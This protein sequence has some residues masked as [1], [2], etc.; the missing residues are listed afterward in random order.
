MPAWPGDSKAGLLELPNQDTNGMAF[1]TDTNINIVGLPFPLSTNP[2]PSVYAQQILQQVPQ[3]FPQQQGTMSNS[4]WNT[5]LGL[6]DAGTCPTQSQASQVHVDML[7]NPVNGSGSNTAYSGYSYQYAAHGHGAAA[8]SSTHDADMDMG[9]ST[10]AGVGMGM[11]MAWDQTAGPA[12]ASSSAQSSAVSVGDLDLAVEGLLGMPGNGMDVDANANANIDD[13]LDLASLDMTL[14]HLMAEADDPTN[15]FGFYDFRNGSI[16]TP[17][18]FECNMHPQTGKQGIDSVLSKIQLYL[19][20]MGGTIGNL[21]KVVGHGQVSTIGYSFEKTTVLSQAVGKDKERCRIVIELHVTSVNGEQ[22]VSVTS[23]PAAVA[24]LKSIDA[25]WMRQFY[26]Q[27]FRSVAREATAAA[28]KKIA[29]S[30]LASARSSA[31]HTAAAREAAAVL[32]EIPR[33]AGLPQQVPKPRTAATPI[34]ST[35]LPRSDD[36]STGTDTSSSSEDYDE[37]E[38]LKWGKYNYICFAKARFDHN[39]EQK[40]LVPP[41]LSFRKGDEIKVLSQQLSGDSLTGWWVAENATGEVGSFPCNFFPKTYS[42]SQEYLAD[43]QRRMRDAHALTKQGSP[44]GADTA[45]ATLPANPES[46][47]ATDVTHWL[48]QSGLAEFSDVVCANGYVGSR[49]LQLSAGQLKTKID[50]IQCDKLSRS[51]D[52]LR[53]KVPLSTNPRTWSTWDVKRWLRSSGLSDFVDAFHASK[54]AGDTILSVSA[55]D[56]ASAE[57]GPRRNDELAQALNSLRT[58]VLPNEGR[59]S[60]AEIKEL[61]NSSTNPSPKYTKVLYD[62]GKTTGEQL[63][64][65]KGE[66]LTVVDDTQGPWWQAR[67]SSGKVGLVPSNFLEVVVGPSKPGKRA[68]DNVTGNLYISMEKLVREHGAPETVP[69]VLDLSVAPNMHPAKEATGAQ[70]V[71][72]KPPQIKLFVGQPSLLVDS[73][74]NKQRTPSI[75]K[76]DTG[77]P[78]DPLSGWS[79]QEEAWFYPLIRRQEAEWAISQGDTGTFLV[80]PSKSN[81][82]SYTLIVKGPRQLREQGHGGV[83][84][85]LIQRTKDAFVLGES[86]LEFGSVTKLIHHYQKVGFPLHGREEIT[87][88]LNR[89]A[90]NLDSPAGIG[91]FHRKVSNKSVNSDASDRSNRAPTKIDLR[92]SLDSLGRKG[93]SNSIHSDASDYIDHAERKGS[94]RGSLLLGSTKSEVAALTAEAAVGA[95]HPKPMPSTMP[96]RF[97]TPASVTPCSKQLEARLK[98]DMDDVQMA[99]AFLAARADAEQ[100]LLNQ[101][102]AAF[103]QWEGAREEI[104]ATA[105]H[106]ETLVDTHH[107]RYTEKVAQAEHARQCVLQCNTGKSYGVILPAA[108]DSKAPAAWWEQQEDVQQLR[109]E[110]WYHGRISRQDAQQQLVDCAPGSYLVRVSEKQLGFAVTAVHEDNKSKRGFTHIMVSMHNDHDGTPTQWMVQ[111][112]QFSSVKQMIEYYKQRPYPS[113]GWFRLCPRELGCFEAGQQ[114]QPHA[115][116]DIGGVFDVAVFKAGEDAIQK[117]IAAEKEAIDEAQVAH[118]VYVLGVAGLNVWCSQIHSTLFPLAL[119]HLAALHETQAVEFQEAMAKAAA[120]FN[121]QGSSYAGLKQAMVSV[122]P[123]T[124]DLMSEL[125]AEFAK[126]MLVARSAGFN[127]PAQTADV[128]D[129]CVPRTSTIALFKGTEKH[130]LALVSETESCIEDLEA[131]I[132]SLKFDLNEIRN[133]GTG[134]EPLD[135]FEPGTL[136]RAKYN[137]KLVTIGGNRNDGTDISYS[138]MQAACQAMDLQRLIAK[139]ETEK[140]MFGVQLDLVQ[141]AFRGPSSK[142]VRQFHDDGFY[143]ELQA[144]VLFAT[145]EDLGRELPKLVLGKAALQPSPAS[146]FTPIYEQ[147]KAKYC[148]RSHDDATTAAAHVPYQT[149]S[150]APAPA[151]TTQATAQPR[152]ALVANEPWF[153]YKVGRREIEQVLTQSG[154]YLVR[155]SNK[156]PGQLALS[157][158]GPEHYQHHALPRSRVTHFLIQQDAR[159]RCSL[160][161][162]TFASIR[163]LVQH[164][165]ETG[166]PVTQASNV[167]LVHGV[168]RAGYGA[169]LSLSDDE[170][171]E[172]EDEGLVLSATQQHPLQLTRANISFGHELTAGKKAS[173][174]VF[175]ASLASTATQPMLIVAVKVGKDTSSAH[176]RQM[177]NEADMLKSC[178]HPNIVRLVGVVEAAL[179]TAFEL[180]DRGDLLSHIRTSAP[181]ISN[182]QR[183]RLSSEVACGLAYLHNKIDG[184]YRVHCDLAAR[185]CLVTAQNTVKI[186]SF[187]KSR[188]F[189]EEGSTRWLNA[190]DSATST[191]TSTD[192]VRWASPE[193]VHNLNFTTSSDVWAFGILL[194]EIFSGGKVPYA[195]LSN[196]ETKTGLLG[197]YLN[198]GGPRISA[199]ASAPAPITQLINE[200]HLDNAPDRPT[201]AD[202][203]DWFADDGTRHG[204]GVVDHTKR[205]A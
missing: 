89:A 8:G 110:P 39:T 10:G 34:L 16:I 128:L 72:F 12:S 141:I 82:G 170:E 184:R 113:V 26:S 28:R 158:F 161:G 14:Q 132:S 183:T 94:G 105:K 126:D 117:A 23:N 107:A 179:Y 81:P 164:Y 6:Q 193:V 55:A 169:R 120:A 100:A 18:W 155:E 195:D 77:G 98:Q 137:Q 116:F 66:I 42:Y 109:A 35:T 157:V 79:M 190:H 140:H 102:R 17:V 188:V 41:P 70:A 3:Q 88:A 84:Q 104:E 73:V 189:D 7:G 108:H 67:D 62:Y 38:G 103:A 177:L 96:P 47:V 69:E 134:I 29:L 122:A 114:Q 92:A 85:L 156:I 27:V 91:G 180:C 133:D 52:T 174:K 32:L 48:K 19:R 86:N 25:L 204:H 154:D 71:S 61:A 99:M 13:M 90:T 144:M 45:A 59:G 43:E 46:W 93:S 5:V 95:V 22:N 123:S 139:K 205:V 172:E 152:P 191:S 142:P 147:I 194:Y 115:A 131:E 197:R 143:Q 135:D 119:R 111:D 11:G 65:T 124:S 106:A 167:R 129:G 149:N 146:S 198:G 163:E 130:L 153:H 20:K 74:S 182:K 171:E 165:T 150:Q 199:P 203:V 181:A 57:L 178:D 148:G 83:L 175:R 36:S 159:G 75:I 187:G 33:R 58:R 54:V 121:V 125:K 185:N 60:Q 192:A 51:L 44:A 145:S 160:E 56:F 30:A 200:C 101:K 97:P 168:V 24:A 136:S 9:M 78:L 64:I 68:D 1:G 76:G 31:N 2:P 112:M 15:I 37:Q 50:P 49:I 202:I 166:L 87:L 162:R 173:I 176:Q 80:R 201:M 196:A 4:A 21:T 118:N 53:S 63:S 138:A 186:A 40:P 127:P 151:Q